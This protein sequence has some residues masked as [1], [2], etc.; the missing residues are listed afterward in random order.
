VFKLFKVLVSLICLAVF[1]WWGVTVR[2]GQRT[3][4]GHIAAIGSSKES[5]ELVRGTKEKVADFKKRLV[6]TDHADKDHVD[7]ELTV[8]DESRPGKTAPPPRGAPQERLT[9]ADRQEVKRLLDMK[10]GAGRAN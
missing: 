3:L 1:V 4:F 5:K 2:L 9:H 7:K 8:R 6:D 10:H